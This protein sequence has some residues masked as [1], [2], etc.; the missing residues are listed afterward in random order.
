MNYPYLSEWSDSSFFIHNVPFLIKKNIQVRGVLHIGAHTCEE[1]KD[2]NDCGIP[3]DRIVWIEG[4]KELCE[5]NKE[6]GIPNVY[7]CL[8]SD[9]EKQVTF[10]ITNNKASSSIF[11]LAA[12]KYYYPHIVE[13]QQVQQQAISLKTF[14]QQNNL[15]PA[16]YNMWNIDIQGAEYDALLGGEMLLDS[17]DVLF[18]E[19][20]FE[21]LYE[22]IPLFNTLETFL[23]GKGFR[24]THMKVW[25]NSWG[26]ALFVREKYL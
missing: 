20:N 24:V 23:K 16:Q 11:P 3:D 6:K 17:V 5:I 9:T 2:Y 13:T 12:H 1:R 19:V 22:N 8:I 15:N 7:N 18:V 25:K 4:N 26:D 21:T 10:H 14:F